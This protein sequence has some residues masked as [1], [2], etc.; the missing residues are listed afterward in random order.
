MNMTAARNN[1]AAKIMIGVVG[2]R[3][4][5]AVRGIRYLPSIPQGIQSFLPPFS[6]S[7]ESGYLPSYTLLLVFSGF[8]SFKKTN[9]LSA[10][11]HSYSCFCFRSPFHRPMA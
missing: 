3:I 11:G 5:E 1:T 7:E 2:Q 6:F 8:F 10:A 4:L 9:V